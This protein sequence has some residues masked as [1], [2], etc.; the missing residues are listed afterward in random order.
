MTEPQCENEKTELRRL[1]QSLVREI[2]YEALQ[3]H[4]EDYE[5]KPRKLDEAE[6]ES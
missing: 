3:G 2:V 5:H 6:M 1:V 4:L